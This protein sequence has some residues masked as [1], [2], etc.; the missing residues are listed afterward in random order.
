MVVAV[1]PRAG[2]GAVGGGRLP[3]LVGEQVRGAQYL[4]GGVLLPG[5][6]LA[7]AYSVVKVAERV[8]ID[9]AV[10]VAVGTET[11]Q[12]HDL[13]VRR[14][15]R[16]GAAG[17]LGGA[18]DWLRYGNPYGDAQPV[19]YNG[20]TAYIRNVENVGAGDD[21]MA[22]RANPDGPADHGA[23][24]QPDVPGP[25]AAPG[26]RWSDW[27]NREA[28]R[29]PRRDW[30]PGSEHS[31]AEWLGAPVPDE[32]SARR[33]ME[34]LGAALWKRLGERCP[35]S[36]FYGY[37]T[38][39]EAA[40]EVSRAL[41]DMSGRYPV[42]VLG[43]V[44][45]SWSSWAEDAQMSAP[46]DGA[47]GLPRAATIAINRGVY[48]SPARALVE[49]ARFAVD[50]GLHY[51]STALRPVYTMVVR[52][53]ARAMLA[54]GNWDAPQVAE[55]ALFTLYQRSERLQLRRPTEEGFMPWARKHLSE[56]SFE[57]DTG[58]ARWRLQPEKALTAAFTEVAVL[59][60]ENVP[61]VLR[62]LHDLVVRAAE[63]RADG[64]GPV[65]DHLGRFADRVLFG[66]PMPVERLD[67]LRILGVRRGSGVREVPNESATASGAGLLGVSAGD[68]S[69]MRTPSEVAAE[70]GAR[71]A[72]PVYGFTDGSVDVEVARDLALSMAGTLGR[73][74]PEGFDYIAIGDVPDG[75]SVQVAAQVNPLTGVVR[76]ISITF[77]A[78]Y[79]VDHRK[80]RAAVLAEAGPKRGGADS[81]A[82]EY[83]PVC[84]VGV[85]AYGRVL[86]LAGGG[87][88]HRELLE[89]L[90]AGEPL[91]DGMYWDI[92]GD[93]ADR[94]GD[95]TGYVDITATERFSEPTVDPAAALADGF[96][97]VVMNPHTASGLHRKAF[98]SL[99]GAVERAGRRGPLGRL[100][101]WVQFGAHALG[102]LPR[103]VVVRET[104]PPVHRN[105]FADM[106][107]EILAGAAGAAGADPFF[108]AEPRAI[109]VTLQGM[110][111]RG[112][113]NA[114]LAVS[115][116]E[117][118]DLN[119]E[120]V[121]EFARAMVD[122][123]ELLS[124]MG[125]AQVGLAESGRFDDYTEDGFSAW[126][127]GTGT[128]EGSS[129]LMFNALHF[130]ATRPDGTPV[131]PGELLNYLQEKVDDAQYPG[132]VLERPVY[133][134]VIRGVGHAVD[135]RDYR[136]AEAEL[137]A[138]LQAYYDTHPDLWEIEYEDWL[139]L[140]FPG[141]RTREQVSPAEGM[142]NALVDVVLRGA[143]RWSGPMRM[144]YELLKS[145]QR[146]QPGF[147]R[148][149]VDG[150]DDNGPE[151]SGTVESASRRMPPGSSLRSRV[152]EPRIWP[153]DKEWPGPVEIEPIEWTGV[154]TLDE[155]E[156]PESGVASDL[157][158]LRNE[159]SE[160]REP[161]DG[162]RDADIPASSGIPQLQ[163]P[164]STDVPWWLDPRS[165]A[166]SPSAGDDPVLPGA[167][168][169]SDR[170][171]EVRD[172][173]FSGDPSAAL[174]DAAPS[175]SPP[176]G[177]NS[178]PESPNSPWSPNASETP[179]PVPPGIPGQ[180]IPPGDP[181]RP[182][183][184]GAYGPG[185]Q[186]LR[187]TPS[188]QGSG[189]SQTHPHLRPV[190]GPGR[191]ITGVSGPPDLPGAQPGPPVAGSGYPPAVPPANPAAQGSGQMPYRN[192]SGSRSGVRG[193]RPPHPS[194][195]EVP[196]IL[197]RPF[198]GAG[199]PAVFDPRTGA[200]Q[201]GHGAVGEQRGVYG[202][203]GTVAVVFFRGPG[204]ELALR[205]G[206][207]YVEC[208]DAVTARWGPAGPRLSRF[209]VSVAGTVLADLTYR[210]LPRELDLGAYISAVLADGDR[211]RTVFG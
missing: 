123:S 17:L 14:A 19:P 38:N 27:P 107:D 64:P 169:P 106:I 15:R 130:R 105:E 210:A 80:F 65:R 92:V 201:V 78:A 48:N 153:E 73:F 7:G 85:R 129:E 204:G 57:L 96:V 190:S 3:G 192:R 102:D 79:A 108:G 59:G 200:L 177:R 30:E 208:S 125:V 161:A 141:Y 72:V 18:A 36:G 159:F 21:D 40:R 89:L 55:R 203:L 42:A 189:Y 157:P 186:P 62:L 71:L 131:D 84:S 149:R 68:W 49:P 88:A 33:S 82:L 41:T 90:W 63:R 25:A 193:S 162:H 191:L 69:T 120:R 56:D 119:P 12:V 43:K 23:G 109:Q 91:A 22:G 46:V 145:H 167:T 156:P 163:P 117:R 54:K 133:A 67:A 44:T 112:T 160:L 52:E 139:Q 76:G 61:P 168:A 118:D 75:A 134:A 174:P 16:G 4:P 13:L 146:A 205:V 81:W 110:L 45:A 83:G 29:D 37:V 165:V 122:I 136:V 154:E 175:W 10:R 188:P 143:D 151:R 60:R 111:R 121:Q 144:V 155:P 97:E 31:D 178:P 195:G 148:G 150:P 124:A 24:E 207:R 8:D 26:S 170:S 211:R 179:R 70:L 176:P 181:D 137:N 116:L 32:W 173:S 184:P 47:T 158:N 100:A 1:A 209:V 126:L 101:D 39:L 180:S 206:E 187:P 34:E 114:E 95:F 50:T 138:A 66:E 53:F 164:V 74:R 194:P 87:Y 94:A 128:G 147:T 171:D 9:G 28:I 113:G 183:Q 104:A 135:Y 166:V 115:G 140:T 142:R 202:D 98:E 35:I 132:A 99:I 103:Q 58:G 127:P 152:P 5:E 172:P 11:R 51:P 77:N 2:G 199:V 197:V 198:A 182:R 6:A 196:V 185:R 86:D 93:S 20:A